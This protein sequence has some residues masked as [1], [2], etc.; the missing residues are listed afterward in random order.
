MAA[1]FEN[2]WEALHYGNLLTLQASFPTGYAARVPS[3]RRLLQPTPRGLFSRLPSRP[4]QTQLPRMRWFTAMCQL[5]HVVKKTGASSASSTRRR[6]KHDDTQKDY[7]ITRAGDR[8]YN[9]K[10]RYLINPPPD[11]TLPTTKP[12]HTQPLLKRSH[13]NASC[14]P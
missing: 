4:P 12:L 10:E 8:M 6:R 7:R 1:H 9:N 11:S 14:K 5:R 3:R 2:T 13:A